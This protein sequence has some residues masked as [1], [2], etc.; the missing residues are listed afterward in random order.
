MNLFNLATKQLIKESKKTSLSSILDRAITIRKWMDRHPK[1]T[2]HILAGGKY[3]R[4]ADGR[5]ALVK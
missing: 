2:K 1:A 3:Y 4:R 5:L